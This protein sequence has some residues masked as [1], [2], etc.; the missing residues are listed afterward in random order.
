MQS[1]TG[2][3]MAFILQSKCVVLKTTVFS[4]IY[5]AQSKVLLKKFS[6]GKANCRAQLAQ[7]VSM[8]F[9]VLET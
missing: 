8:F 9:E 1:Y 2:I 5:Y 6:I 7:T 3:I 4:D